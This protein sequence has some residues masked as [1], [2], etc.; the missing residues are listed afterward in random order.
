MGRLLAKVEALQ[1]ENEELKDILE[2]RDAE[3]LSLS[4]DMMAKQQPP[5]PPAVPKRSPR[6]ATHLSS[7]LRESLPVHRSFTAWP[8]SHGQLWHVPGSPGCPQPWPEL[9]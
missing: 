9:G 5:K 2:Q 7:A 4:N 3:I 1:V 8:G 6:S